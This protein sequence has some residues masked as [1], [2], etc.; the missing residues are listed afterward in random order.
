M[1]LT[2]FKVCLFSLEPLFCKFPFGDFLLE[3]VVC[4]REF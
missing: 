3:L 2:A 1:R 4:G